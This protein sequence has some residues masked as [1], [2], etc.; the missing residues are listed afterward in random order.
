MQKPLEKNIKIIS[1]VLVAIVLCS[2]LGYLFLSN[3]NTIVT[4]IINKIIPKQARENK[5]DLVKSGFS[6]TGEQETA[7]G[8]KPAVPYE[9]VAI[10][11][12]ENLN[13]FYNEEGIQFS[14][15]QKQALEASGFFLVEN[16]LIKDQ[17]QWNDKDD[18]VDTYDVFDGS[19][20]KYYRKENNAIFISSDVALHLYHIL[21]DRSFQKMEETK[22]QPMLRSMTRVLFLDSINRYNAT[23]DE[24]LKESYKRLSAYYLVPLVV[25]DAGNESAG[26]NLEPENYDTF[27]QYL[28]AVNSEEIANSEKDFTFALNQKMYAGVELSDEIFELAQSELALIQAAK[29]VQSSPL[30]T[31]F[32][33]EFMNDY[34]QFKPR[35]HY[36][37]N[38]ILKSYFISMMWYG[39]MGFALKSP[40]LTR[41]ALIITG[42]INNLK[43]GDEELSKMWSDMTVVIDFF[44]GEVDDLTAYQYT[45]LIKKIY[46]DSNVLEK[47][48]ADDQKLAEFMK[49]A[50]A[51]LPAPKI[52]SE[53]LDVYDDGGERDKL[54]ADIKQFRFMGQR[55]T[56][57][58]YIINNLTQGAGGPDPETGQL[59]PT[60]PTALMPIHLIEPEN[61]L[62]EN[63]LNEWIN[64]PVRIEEQGRQSDKIIAKVNNKLKQEFAGYNPA[65]WTQNIYWSWLNCFKSL[66]A[67]YG[68]GYP[69]FMQTE[70]WLRKNLGTVLGSFTELKHDTLLYA[71]QSYA[72]MGGGGDDPG[73][74]PPVVKGYVEPD[75]VFWDRIITLAETTEQGLKERNVFPEE[76]ESKYQDF[77]NSAKFFKQITEQELQNQKISD[78][79]FEKLRTINSS[80][81]RIT[82]PLSGQELTEKEK[83]AG[84]IADIHTDAVH[85]QILYEATGKPFIVYVAVKDANGTRLTRG[86]VFNHYEFSDVLDGRLSDEDW[87]IKVYEEKGPLPENDE[88]SRELIK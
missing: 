58:A 78:D 13:S 83:R 23:N 26:L 3:H 27:A 53:A 20:D 40:E 25:L 68:E 41:D 46:G 70:D 15:A 31:P 36:T 16:D 81:S 63:Y 64:D 43:V 28:E 80:L 75:L 84:I 12:I 66:L 67:G 56:P 38:D 42:Q 50:K 74:L 11:E 7:G 18:F 82:Q 2:F 72:E 51:D 55:F 77:I 61:E 71:K 22:F 10:G 9:K 1:L 88:W 49:K 34:S 48:F 57:D 35:S 59:L 76:F 69:Y 62:V 21:I 30:F 29:G 37:K 32:R 33:P 6:Q 24:K 52:V 79:D 39:R 19:G 5:F 54:L 65:V 17:R 8:I 87:Q 47:D 45:D 60:M 14:E 73:E 86:V 44:V 4:S 85:N